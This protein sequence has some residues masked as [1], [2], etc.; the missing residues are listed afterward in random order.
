[1]AT[2]SS[3]NTDI[4]VEYLY[5]LSCYCITAVKRKQY[6]DIIILKYQQRLIIN[7]TAQINMEA[8]YDD[9]VEKYISISEDMINKINGNIKNNKQSINEICDDII[10]NDNN[11]EKE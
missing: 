2:I 4:S 7:T 10:K 3:K 6:L 9:N 11:K 8:Y 5:K 1:V